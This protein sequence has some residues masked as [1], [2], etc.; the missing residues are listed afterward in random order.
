[1]RGVVYLQLFETNLYW[2]ITNDFFCS[3][4]KNGLKQFILIT[5]IVRSLSICASIHFK[6]NALVWTIEH[7]CEA[8]NGTSQ[9]WSITEKR[10]PS[11]KKRVPSVLNKCNREVHLQSQVESFFL[12]KPTS[13]RNPKGNLQL[14]NHKCITK[15]NSFRWTGIWI[16]HLAFP[17]LIIMVAH[18]DTDFGIRQLECLG[19]S[20][21]LS[22][23]CSG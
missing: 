13:K 11:L 4:S 22:R 9:P 17:R 10:S 20:L 3:A 6:T 12:S 14:Q 19:L 5:G 15:V 1:M 21:C 8:Y 18:N 2:N 23:Q 16:V 7:S